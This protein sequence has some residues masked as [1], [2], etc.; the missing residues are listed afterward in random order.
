M[1]IYIAALHGIDTEILEYTRIDGVTGVKKLLYIYIPLIK[2]P[3]LF[4]VI[5]S[6][7]SQFNIYGQP[8][9]LTRGGPTESTFVLIMYIQRIAFG[10]G[11]PIAGMASSMAVLLG[12]CIGILSVIQMRSIIKQSA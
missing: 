12:L 2:L 4:T 8:L 6:T 3:L 1:L 10:T 5:S 7:A 9:L 11:R